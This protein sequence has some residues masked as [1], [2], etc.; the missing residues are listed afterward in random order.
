MQA[1]KGAAE[2][3]L[4]E[5]FLDNYDDKTNWVV[6]EN[7]VGVLGNATLEEFSQFVQERTFLSD[8]IRERFDIKSLFRQ[9]VIL[10]VYFTTFKKR[11]RLARE[12]EFD[13]SILSHT[14]G[15]LGLA[16]PRDR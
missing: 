9:P 2:S 15:D 1:A 6:A 14:Y 7:L 11:T 10:L 16:D 3:S 8:R 5:E 4:G 12:W 13:D